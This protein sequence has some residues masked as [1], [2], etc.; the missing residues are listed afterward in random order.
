MATFALR[1]RLI[2]P[3]PGILYFFFLHVECVLLFFF[4]NENMLRCYITIVIFL[5]LYEQF[6]API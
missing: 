4:L 3:S 6:Q 1:L 5:F 2:S